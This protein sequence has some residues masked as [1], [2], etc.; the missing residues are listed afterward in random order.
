MLNKEPRRSGVSEKLRK[1]LN[2]K[3]LQINNLLNI[4]QAINNNLSATDLYNMY[5][6]FLSWEMGI[7]KMALFIAEDDQYECVTSHGIGEYIVHFDIRPFI[8]DFSKMQYVFNHKNEVISQFD[9][10]IPVFHK[11]QSL[12]FS[13]IGGAS[14]EG[15]IIERLQFIITITNIIA[16]AI[17]NKRLFKQQ[18]ERELLKQEMNLAMSMQKKLMPSHFPCRENI[19][20]HGFYK[21]K[22]DVGG[23]YFDI[24]EHSEEEIIFTIADISGKGVAAALLMSNIQAILRTLVK[25]N[26][27]LS[28]ILKELDETIS[29]MMEGDK[30]A[31]MFVAKYNQKKKLLS[32]V[33]AGHNPPLIHYL[34]QEKPSELLEATSSVLGSMSSYDSIKEHDVHISDPAIL[35]MYTDGL[36]EIMNADGAFYSIEMIDKMIGTKKRLSSKQINEDIINEAKKFAAKDVFLDDLTLLTC[37]LN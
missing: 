15:D 36:T 18:V 37:K 19:R 13:L 16:V 23:D 30:F 2:L 3:Q 27:G 8:E 22:L 28:E 32:Y 11:N 29:E 17:E 4:T 21:P 33:N 25:R 7:E 24:I 35:I 34:N 9:V 26:I 14:G 10:V 6:S 5:K 31:S 20:F 1:E 12:A